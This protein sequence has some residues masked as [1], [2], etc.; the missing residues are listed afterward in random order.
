MVWSYPAISLSKETLIKNAGKSEAGRHTR[1]E[2]HAHD[3]CGL[4]AV[5]C[6]LWTVDGR[7]WTVDGRLWTVDCESC[8]VAGL[9][10]W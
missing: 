10:R 3:G 4:W 1:A 6:G 7:L 5:S 2:Y 8:E 9:I